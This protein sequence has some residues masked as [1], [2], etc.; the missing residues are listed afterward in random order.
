MYDNTGAKKRVKIEGNVGMI[1]K[2][3]KKNKGKSTE[4]RK[5][6]KTKE[7]RMVNK[8]VIQNV[9]NIR[10][11]MKYERKNQSKDKR[12]KACYERKAKK[13][14]KKK[15][16]RMEKRRERRKRIKNK[17]KVECSTKKGGM[18][19]S[20]CKYGTY[21]TQGT[22]KRSADRPPA[23][24]YTKKNNKHRSV[25]TQQTYT[26]QTQLQR[27][28]GASTSCCSSKEKC[29]TTKC[30]IYSTRRTREKIDNG[31]RC[32]YMYVITRLSL[33]VIS[34]IRLQVNL[35]LITESYISN[36]ENVKGA[37]MDSDYNLQYPVLGQRKGKEISILLMRQY[38][39]CKTEWNRWSS[40]YRE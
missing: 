39:K 40:R 3:Q 6:E 35:K 34:N 25:C 2:N 16:G 9:Q 22:R 36:M 23:I 38:K 37:P 17:I 13:V 32:N 30:V 11:E 14:G 28:Y 1:I 33:S 7:N 19:N 21:S 31:I 12:T 10:K 8:E 26:V 4:N 15:A 5:M 29:E 24:R 27:K 20:T 18:S